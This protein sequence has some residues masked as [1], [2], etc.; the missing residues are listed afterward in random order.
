[1]GSHS[2][3]PLNFLM[4]MFNVRLGR[5]CPNPRKPVWTNS[6]P[7]IGLF[8][9]I[10]ELFGMTNADANYVYLSDG[11]H[12]ENLGIYELVRRRCRLIVAVDVASDKELAFEDL[13]NAIRKCATDLHVG[14]E[15]CVARMDMV[16]GTDMCGASCA[17]GRIRYSCVDK[18]GID[19]VL[20]YV[21]PAIVGTENADVLNYRRAHP[22]Y[23]HQSTADQWFDEAQF[24]SYRAL[25]YHIMKC[26]LAEAAAATETTG[27]AHD[28]DLLCQELTRRHSGPLKPAETPV[29]QAPV[30]VELVR[31]AEVAVAMAGCGCGGKAASCTCRPARD[32]SLC[33]DNQHVVPAEAGTHAGQALPI[34]A[35]TADVAPG[36]GFPTTA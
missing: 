10:A 17:A 21:K 12:F 19:G 35:S 29:P 32:A 6:S 13:G 33:H 36:H 7:G 30:Q 2:S 22:D 34:T 16:K 18:D 24:E 11:G 5:W 25:G 26:A 9:L 31:E 4:T 1:M 15:L 28:I 8:S 20:L 14:I 23:P 27:G 3:P